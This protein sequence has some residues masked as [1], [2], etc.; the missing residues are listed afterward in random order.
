MS[1]HAIEDLYYN[2]D[3]LKDK[4]FE[5]TNYHLKQIR[6]LNSFL[7]SII[8]SKSVTC[9]PIITDKIQVS[10]SNILDNVLKKKR[11]HV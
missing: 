10:M 9:E 5:I 3:T 11:Y 2:L 1:N 7:E 4:S 8:K 6:S